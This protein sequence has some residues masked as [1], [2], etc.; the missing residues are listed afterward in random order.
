MCFWPQ[1]RAS[2]P[3]AGFWS[4]I[5]S[6]TQSVRNILLYSRHCSWT[7]HSVSHEPFWRGRWK[8]ANSIWT[9]IRTEDPKMSSC[10]PFFQRVPASLQGARGR[11]RRDWGHSVWLWHCHMAWNTLASH[12]HQISSLT[13]PPLQGLPEPTVWNN[14]TRPIL[15]ITLPLPTLSIWIAYDICWHILTY[16]FVVGVPH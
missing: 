2:P 15:S 9:A 3:A 10:H 11:E 4:C 12:I 14:N 16:S 13:S 7:G 8:H 6:A 5:L 1:A